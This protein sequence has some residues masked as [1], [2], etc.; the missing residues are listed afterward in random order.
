MSLRL[1]FSFFYI[2]CHKFSI[3]SR[4]FVYRLFLFSTTFM[5]F[6]VV[7]LFLSHSVSMFSPTSFYLLLHDITFNFMS[8]TCPSTYLFFFLNF[9]L[10]PSFFFF[11]LLF[12]FL[13]F[14]LISTIY[15]MYM[16]NFCVAI[17]K[18]W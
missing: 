3:V 15:N 13:F 5:F 14:L 18:G 12:F 16:S 1:Q 2:A 11:F 6:R 4:F 17:T 8:T 10:F 7:S 9:L